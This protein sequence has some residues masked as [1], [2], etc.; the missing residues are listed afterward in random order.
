MRAEKLRAHK[1]Y[2]SDESVQYFLAPCSLGARQKIAGVT[3][4][5]R[6]PSVKRLNL[7][8]FEAGSN[9]MRSEL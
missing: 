1:E 7:R 5:P 2:M 3:R 8:M 6:E 9:E 4:M